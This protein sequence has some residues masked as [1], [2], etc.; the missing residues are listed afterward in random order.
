LSVRV[1]NTWNIR[2]SSAHPV[3]T[4]DSGP[5][6]LRLQNGPQKQNNPLNITLHLVFLDECLPALD[7][8]S[9]LRRGTHQMSLSELTPEI[10]CLIFKSVGFT[11]AG[12]QQ[13]PCPDQR[14]S[15][16]PSSYTPRMI[17]EK[18]AVY[19]NHSTYSRPRFC[20]GL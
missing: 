8:S 4:P 6:E 7:S 1:V 20:T 17:S 12:Q 9:K 3:H 10:L 13:V 11:H 18:Y 16:M 2:F 19:R 15:M 14:N 5:A